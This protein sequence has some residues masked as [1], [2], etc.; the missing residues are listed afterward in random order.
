MGIT[1]TPDGNTRGKE[2]T[3]AINAG[4]K[5]TADES[6]A[7]KFDGITVAEGY[8]L[9]LVGQI[10]G[11]DKAE[12]SGFATALTNNGTMNVKDM[13][14]TNNT[15]DIVNNNGSTLTLSGT[16]TI[17][18]I[19]NAGTLTIAGA[20]STIGSVTGEGATSV[21]NGTLTVNG[22]FTQKG[23]TVA[24]GASYEQTA[25]SF[26]VEGDVTN[27]GNVTLSGLGGE[28]T[29]VLADAKNKI[30][31][32]LTNNGTFA[33][34]STYLTVNKL[35]GNVVN[36]G[37]NSGIN[38]VQGISAKEVNVEKGSEVTAENLKATTVETKGT[39]IAKEIAAETVSAT[40]TVK[41]ADKI[42]V[43]KSAEIT[44]LIGTD[45]AKK[46]AMEVNAKSVAE[47]LIQITD[48]KNVAIEVAESGESLLQKAA[49]NDEACAKL[50]DIVANGII[51]KGENVTVHANEGRVVGD[52]TVTFDGVGNKTV[53]EKPNK[54]NKDIVTSLADSVGFARIEMNDIR[55]RLGDVRVNNAPNGMWARYE[56]GKMEGSG[57][58]NKFNKLQIGSDKAVSNIWRVGGAFSYTNGKTDY[59]KGSNK[60]KTYSAA[61][62][63][64]YTGQKGEYAD[65]IARIG[66]DKTDVNANLAKGDLS[67]PS[68]AVS[69]EVGK[70]IDFA[71]NFYIEP[72]AELTYT[73]TKG[74][75]FNYE[76]VKYDVH[77]SNSFTG[78][79]GFALGYKTPE[80]KGT[81]YTRFSVL[82]EFA[83]DKELQVSNGTVLRSNIVD[84]KQTWYEWAVGGQFNTSKCTYVY[85]DLEKTFK[86]DI[87]EKYRMTVGLRYSF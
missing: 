14:L 4:I 29:T 76:G 48:A 9:N 59:D 72:Q 85:V 5:L 87:N 24:N 35:E 44:K 21:N 40:G 30:T 20:S 47:K 32:T 58:E 37:D 33:L 27:N 51:I 3:L 63:A 81:V 8:T 64:V 46:A 36:V 43:E 16:N 41:V 71:K 83:G 56:H 22:D 19:E 74:D 66:V 79:L 62:Y 18:S 39:L 73:F 65:I 53:V 78:R 13:V 26:V 7:P 61:G 52:T 23:L 86:A 10:E 49:Y 60:N 31:G 75:D 77:N 67:N 70:T 54:G 2:L 15:K 34:E 38:V 68:F 69:G 84:G 80:N 11:E 17:D 82:H 25:G 45:S 55:K 57:I 50:A 6:V 12:M 42:T 28:T 1:D